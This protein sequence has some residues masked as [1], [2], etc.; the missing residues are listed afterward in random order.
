LIK[1]SRNLLSECKNRTTCQTCDYLGNVAGQNAPNIFEESL[2]GLKQ[3]L[4]PRVAVLVKTG[5]T[6]F[7]IMNISYLCK[8]ASKYDLI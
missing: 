3:T 7:E 1:H 8:Y 6:Y 5:V 2:E 4:N